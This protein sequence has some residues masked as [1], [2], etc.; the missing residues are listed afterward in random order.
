MNHFKATVEAQME[1][2]RFTAQYNAR[3]LVV[4]RPS[5]RAFELVARIELA[6]QTLNRPAFDAA[7]AELAMLIERL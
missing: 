1:S 6:K 5:E 2:H 3:P 4:Q 7:K